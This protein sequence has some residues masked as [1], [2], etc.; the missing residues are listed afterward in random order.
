VP[1]VLATDAGTL[2]FFSATTIFGSP[3]DVTLSELAIESFLPA[4]AHTA[5]ALERLAA[6]KSG[7]Q[8]FI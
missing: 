6:A 3:V 8:D 1:L 5:R 2:S 4:D 7:A